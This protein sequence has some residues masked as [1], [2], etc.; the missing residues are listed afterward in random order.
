VCCL[1]FLDSLESLV[2]LLEPLVDLLEPLVVAVEA[3]KDLFDQFADV[4][5]VPREK[6]L[7]EVDDLHFVPHLGDLA[8]ELAMLVVLI[9]VPVFQYVDSFLEVVDTPLPVLEGSLLVWGLGHLEFG[10]VAE[11]LSIVVTGNGATQ[12]G[13]LL[14]ALLLN[15][16]SSSVRGANGAGWLPT[17]RA[18]DSPG[19]KEAVVGG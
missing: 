18:G 19:R 2:D 9:A 13:F 6:V 16:W 11:V 3:P 15:V 12:P 7:T 10:H 4:D 1:R 5:E 14:G 17:A 8:N